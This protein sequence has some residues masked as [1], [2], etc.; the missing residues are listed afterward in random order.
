[1]DC[2]VHRVAESQTRLS[3]F[4][5]LTLAALQASPSC[6][7]CCSSLRL[8]TTESVMPSNHLNLCHSLLFLP[9][10]FFF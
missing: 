4:H 5:S 10:I 9:S 8:M 6:T 7:I 1:M 2:I 3:D